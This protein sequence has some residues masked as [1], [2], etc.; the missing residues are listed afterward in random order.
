VRHKYPRGETLKQAN[1]FINRFMA[2]KALKGEFSPS[3]FWAMGWVHSSQKIWW[4]R[5]V[6]YVIEQLREPLL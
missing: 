4:T 6:S 2:V 3:E 5:M 1:S